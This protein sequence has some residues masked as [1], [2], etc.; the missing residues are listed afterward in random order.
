MSDLFDRLSPADT[1]TTG[2]DTDADELVAAASIEAYVDDRATVQHI[3]TGNGPLTRRTVDWDAVQRPGENYRSLFVITDYRLLVIVGGCHDPDIDQDYLKA[4]PLRD[5]DTVEYD[6]SFTSSE[7]TVTNSDGVSFSLTPAH[8]DELRVALEFL[9]KASARWSNAYAVLEEITVAADELEMAI[10]RNDADAIETA[11]TNARKIVSD[12]ENRGYH[13][14]IDVPALD[15]Q[16]DRAEDEIRVAQVRGHCRRAQSHIGERDGQSN[17]SI[18]VAEY[19]TACEALGTAFELLEVVNSDPMEVIDGSNDTLELTELLRMLS[20]KIL[21]YITGWESEPEKMPHQEVIVLLEAYRSLLESSIEN[22]EIETIDEY[23]TELVTVCEEL[24][25]TGD[26]LER[27]A[28]QEF[29]NG[30]EDTA[31]A[32]YTRAIA[33][34]ESYQLL[35][36]LSGVREEV[37]TSDATD[38]LDQLRRKRKKSEWQWGNR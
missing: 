23:R 20:R 1:Q 19:T 36:Q 2:V 25:V 32:T 8:D 18:P 17:R 28:D 13:E 16:I 35:G 31:E 10:A 12:L 24:C 14:D 38:K 37:N 15:R 11:R 27:Q 6:K 4:I 9:R 22:V 3:V 5:I 26:A 34:L 33:C 29:E 21:D 30:S 7:L